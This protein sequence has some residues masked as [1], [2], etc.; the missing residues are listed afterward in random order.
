[1]TQKILPASPVRNAKGYW[2][3]SQYPTFE[4]GVASAEIA[5]ALNA[6]GVTS[7]AFTEMQHDLDLDHPAY[8]RYFDDGE[9]DIHDWNPTPPEGEGWFLLSIHDTEDGPVAVF[10][11]RSDCSQPVT[12]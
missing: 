8:V 5:S 9:A 4:E 11:S 1:M 10:G 12:A 7:W 3:H 2:T 6:A